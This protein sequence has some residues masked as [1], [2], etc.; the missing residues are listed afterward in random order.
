MMWGYYNPGGMWL[1]MTISALVGLA[2]IVAIVAW[3]LARSRR[4]SDS[5]ATSATPSA[6]EILDQRY[7][8]G[9]LD[10]ATY[11]RMREALDAPASE[12]ARL[13]VRAP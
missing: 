7:A 3:A 6:R 2:V 11:Q 4:A 5:D 9:E 8:R 12:H 1:W 13:P 10:D